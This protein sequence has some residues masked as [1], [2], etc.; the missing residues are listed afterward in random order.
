M[1]TAVCLQEQ[2]HT[3]RAPL[4]KSVSVFQQANKE[5]IG[6]LLNCSESGLMISSYDK[7]TPGTRLQLELMDIPP[8]LDIHRKGTCTIEVV[9]SK[10]ITPSLYGT[11]CRIE[12]ASDSLHKMLRSYLQE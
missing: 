1:N 3:Y 7:I 6:L 2:R 4:N 12:G 10:L 8:H 11:G 9:W 5:Y